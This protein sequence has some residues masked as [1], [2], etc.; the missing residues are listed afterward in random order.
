[1]K[2]ISEKKALLYIGSDYIDYCFGCF[3]NN[4]KVNQATLQKQEIL[5]KNGNVLLVTS[6]NRVRG[7][8]ISEKCLFR[9][10]Q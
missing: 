1:M 10:I 4:L 8:I 9:Y 5:R 2:L 6:Q 7:Y 3:Y